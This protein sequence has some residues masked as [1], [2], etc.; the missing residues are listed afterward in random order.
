[1]HWVVQAPV[2]VMLHVPALQLTDEPAPTVTVHEVPAHSTLEF[3]PVFPVQ[4][5]PEAQLNDEV[6]LDRSPKS[7]VAFEGHAQEFPEQTLGEQPASPK[8]ESASP[9]RA[10]RSVMSV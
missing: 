10:L 7:Q 3:A 8:S 5:A 6:A 2:Q 1:M 9:K 4:V